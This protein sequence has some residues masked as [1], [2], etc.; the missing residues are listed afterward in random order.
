MQHS[1]NQSLTAIF[2]L[3]CWALGLALEW[4]YEQAGITETDTAIV[5]RSVWR[6]L[7]PLSLGKPSST[8]CFMMGNHLCFLPEHHWFTLQTLS[9]V[10]TAPHCYYPI[11]SDSWDRGH[12]TPSLP[13]NFSV[14]LH[15]DF[16]HMRQKT[17]RQKAGNI[18]FNKNADCNSCKGSA[19]P[20]KGLSHGDGLSSL[21]SSLSLLHSDVSKPPCPSLSG[22]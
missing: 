7:L 1:V 9:S 4:G 8:W 14:V 13:V 12:T 19:L 18:W 22:L 20:P 16:L 15:P 3:A 10:L 2:L 6:W 17:R 21:S 5:Q 11:C